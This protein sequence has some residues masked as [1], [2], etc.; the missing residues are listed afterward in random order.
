[1]KED[2]ISVRLIKS[3]DQPEW[4][5]LYRGYADFYQM[6]MSDETLATVFGWLLDPA[7]VLEGF[8]MERDETLVGL[9]HVR[10]MPSP[11]RGATGGFLDDLFIHPDARG[12]R[13]GEAMLTHLQ[14]VAQERGWGFIR[15]ITAEDNARARTLYDRVAT[16]T[17]WVLYQMD[18]R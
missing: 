8:V 12:S 2:D 18:P 11:L 7:H 10:V 6:P 1:M 13:L 15:W 4:Q 17:D 5:G 3:D 9:A 14:T 16:K